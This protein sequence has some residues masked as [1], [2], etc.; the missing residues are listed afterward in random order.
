MQKKRSLLAG[1]VNVASIVVSV[2]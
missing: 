2:L 1:G